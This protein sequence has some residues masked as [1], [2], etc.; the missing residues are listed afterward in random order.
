MK[1]SGK[2]MIRSIDELLMMEDFYERFEYCKLGGIVGDRTFGGSRYLNQV[3]YSSSD[4]RRARREVILRD[5]GFDLA[6]EDH[7]IGGSIYVHH[8]NPITIEDILNRDRKVFKP[9][10]LVSC[11]FQTHESLHYG[12]MDPNKGKVII[13]RKNDTCP[14]KE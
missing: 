3:L 14:W 9:D 6:H 2:K 5:N 13:R 12:S 11:S 4:W 7:P 10:Y 8:L 1:E